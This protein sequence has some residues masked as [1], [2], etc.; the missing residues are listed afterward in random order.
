MRRYRVV[1]VPNGARSLMC[2]SRRK[3]EGRGPDD[4]ERSVQIVGTAD[5]PANLRFAEH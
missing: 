3:M 1:A 2:H 4:T 5:P